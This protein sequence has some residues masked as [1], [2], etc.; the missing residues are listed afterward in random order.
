MAK[1]N[2]DRVRREGNVKRKS[3]LPPM[4]HPTISEIE[5]IS[6]WKRNLSRSRK[7]ILLLR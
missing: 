5:E 3:T 2:W 4:R 1:M 7:K 6:R